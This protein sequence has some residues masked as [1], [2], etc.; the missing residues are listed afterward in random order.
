M[1]AFAGD[2]ALG[3][4]AGDW[5]SGSGDVVCESAVILVNAGSKSSVFGSV[6]EIEAWS[7][8]HGARG[9]LAADGVEVRESGR[10]MSFV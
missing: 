2:I 5:V 9:E 8:K 7:E 1:C 6:L 3:V 10:V 4:R